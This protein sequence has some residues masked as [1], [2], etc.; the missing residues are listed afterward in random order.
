LADLDAL[1]RDYPSTLQLSRSVIGVWPEHRTYLARNFKVR[2][3]EQMTATELASSSILKLIRGEEDRF[4]RHYR[5]TCDRLN[6]EELFFHRNGRYR[7][8]TFAEALAEVYSNNDYMTRYMD[9]LLLTQSLWFNHAAAFEMFLNRLL[10]L[11]RRGARYLEIGP[12]HGLMT[13]FA[14]RTPAIDT[15]E[16]W[17]VSSVS[18][19]ETRTAL[20]VLG[21]TK[22]VSFTEVDILAADEAPSRYDMVVISE[23]LEHLERPGQALSF[24]NSAL[25]PGGLI[26][27]NVPIN[28]PSP[29]HIYLIEHPAAGLAL[30]EAAGFEIVSQELYATQ[31][32]AI[33]KALRDRISISMAIV[34]RKN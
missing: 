26:Y 6:E 24:L 30:I 28:S 14:A 12:G 20:A 9:G 33:E 10:P 3:P 4:A 18:L 15:L 21:I 13:Y 1:L 32:R 31:G 11:A 34:G 16:V 2:S 7:L 8:T 25:D 5:W 29:D 27:V 23:V 22:T 17:D 19:D